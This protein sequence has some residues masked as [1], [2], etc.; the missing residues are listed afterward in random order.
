MR[1]I[2]CQ[3]A[4]LLAALL[5]ALTGCRER[6][7]ELPRHR[8][9]A[10]FALV[11]SFGRPVSRADLT[12]RVSV[13][14]FFLSSCAASSIGVT[15]R[16]AELQKQTAGLS[17]VALFSLTVDPQA[18]Q[19]ATLRQYG[20]QYGA[21]SNRWRFVTGPPNEVRGL[22]RGSFLSDEAAAKARRSGSDPLLEQCDH[23]AVVDRDGW[24]RGWLDG[25]RFGTVPKVMEVVNALRTNATP[26]GP[27]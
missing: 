18:D 27:R 19:P 17:G 24:V 9:V 26:V 5:I 21:D 7:V 22:I 6:A 10:A 11:D 13:V 25:T 23:L 8:E 12:G 20:L 15:K 3:G 1:R 14:S 2:T 4:A 16:M